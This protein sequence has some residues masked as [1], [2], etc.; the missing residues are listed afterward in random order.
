M[1]LKMNKKW[2]FSIIVMTAIFMLLMVPNIHI[3]TVISNDEVQ[4]ESPTM[5]IGPPYKAALMIGG[6]ET[7]MGFSYVAI[8]AI[9]QLAVIYG[10]EVSISR[11]VEYT[12][13]ISVASSYGADGYDVVF[14]V[15]GQFITEV[16]RTDSL[17]FAQLYNET[18]F[19]QIPGLDYWGLDTPD[20]VVGLHPAFQ[21]EGMYLAGVLAGLMTETNRTAVVFGQWFGYLSMEFF[22]FKAGVKSV[23]NDSC[24]YARVAG[25]WGDI[26]LGKQITKALIET[27][28]VDIVVQVADTTGRGVIA[29]AVEADITVIGTVGDQAVLAPDNTMTSIGMDTQKLME[30]VVQYVE[31]GTHM[32]DLANKTWDIPI[33][34]Y[35]H[36]YHNYDSIIPQSV[37][38]K[39]DDV[40][41]GI[42]NGTIIVPRI[43]EP[44]APAD[45]PGCPNVS[46]EALIPGFPLFYLGL[47]V[48][49][50]LGLM[51]LLVNRSR[52][53]ANKHKS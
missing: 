48:A 5:S 30:L 22:A 9:N 10:W 21:T 17:G 36:P 20:N 6:D 1:K 43:D 13:I 15:G 24:V 33:G 25:T 53:N 16:Y 40:K 37:K 12:D 47:T 51:V 38:D 3:S 26:A 35:L 4:T 23:N 11:K 46:D 31:N 27:K 2:R 44:T 28:N 14:L 41:A 34:N 39:V 19:V 7:D 49:T 8:Q 42:A 52:R 32:S 45:E 50:M 29:A 18:L